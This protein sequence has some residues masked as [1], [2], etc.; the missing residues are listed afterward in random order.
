MNL[1]VVLK[2]LMGISVFHILDGL[3]GLLN[4]RG[5]FYLFMYDGARF[6]MFVKIAFYFFLLVFFYKI[7]IMY[8]K[9]MEELKKNTKITN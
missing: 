6:Y 9:E 4:Q 5:L 2:T 1:N 3:I 7:F 8:K